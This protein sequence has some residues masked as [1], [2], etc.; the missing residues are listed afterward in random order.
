[1]QKRFITAAEL[2]R[3]AW[4]FAI[5]LFR[6]GHRFEWVIGVARGG[7]QIAV[8]VQ[9]ALALLSG[10]EVSF[11][12]V[13]AW[14]YT[15]VGQAT[16]AV[17]MRGLDAAVADVADGDTVLLVDDVFDRGRT[18]A[19]LKDEM[20]RRLAGR[21]VRLLTAV[22]YFKPDSRQ[23]PL[24]PDFHHRTFPATEWLVFPHELRGLTRE[25]L[26]AKGFAAGPAD[27]NAPSASLR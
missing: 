23:V 4:D 11:A 15:G 13:Q 1:M 24:L 17:A 20:D 12:A 21:H 16:A 9:E 3:D 27:G 8:Y 14:S 19:A 5:R 10:R 18:L 26:L 6:E 7:C 22:L 2:E 25:E